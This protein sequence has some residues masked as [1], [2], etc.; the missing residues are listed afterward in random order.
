M[1]IGSQNPP[2]SESLIV[3]SAGSVTFVGRDGV[4]LFRATALWSALGMYATCGI[5]PNRQWTLS[6]MLA[7][8]TA[9][10]TGKKY[11]KSRAGAAQARLDVRVWMDTMKTALPVVEG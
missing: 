4:N 8:A 7:M 10:Y 5:I 11:P 2:S 6:V 3:R 9:D 1:R